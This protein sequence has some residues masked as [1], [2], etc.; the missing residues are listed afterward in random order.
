MYANVYSEMKPHPTRRTNQGKAGLRAAFGSQPGAGG[1]RWNRWPGWTLRQREV[2][3]C[4]FSYGSR[5]RASI[6]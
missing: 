3:A 4:G 1:V 6:S 5:H 2:K